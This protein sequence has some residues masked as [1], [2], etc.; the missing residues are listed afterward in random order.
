MP[1]TYLQH[2]R[3]AIQGVSS[4]LIFPCIYISA[5]F[6][7]PSNFSYA[8]VMSDSI[9]LSWNVSLLSQ[10]GREGVGESVCVR[11]CVGERVWES[12]GETDI[13]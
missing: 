3:G 11:G 7:A 13:L 4:I 6:L 2:T 5:D 12:V 9:L 10:C 1:D 8:S